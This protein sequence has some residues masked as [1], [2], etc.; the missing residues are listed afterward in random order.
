MSYGKGIKIAL[1][2]A[3][4]NQNKLAERLGV[5]RQTVS[6]WCREKSEP[7]FKQLQEIAAALNI[8]TPYLVKLGEDDESGNANT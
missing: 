6:N 1:V 4:L 8:T 2:K 3:G 7:R 5:T